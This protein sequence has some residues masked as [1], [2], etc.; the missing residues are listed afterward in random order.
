MSSGTGSSS[1]PPEA[2]VLCIDLGTT[3]CKIAVVQV[4]GDSV[5]SV[6]PTTVMES[7]AFLRGVGAYEEFG[8]ELARRGANIEQPS[9]G[10]AVAFPVPISHLAGGTEP[11][12]MSWPRGVHTIEEQLGRRFGS[13]R[14]TML[15]DAVAFALGSIQ[16]EP[17]GEASGRTLYLTLGMDFGGAIAEPS[18][19]YVTPAELNVLL[20]GTVWPNGH[21]G[22]PAQILMEQ[23]YVR[24]D[25]REW[26]AEARRGFGELTGWVAGE[27]SKRRAV[28][29]VVL[30]GGRAN[31]VDVD[32]VGRGMR[33]V[34][35]TPPPIRIDG[36]DESAL[37]GA[38]FAWVTRY[39][40]RRP[41]AE[42]IAEP[43]AQSNSR[44]R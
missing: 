41:L 20:R 30:G 17:S 14:V 27:V 31:I 21:R 16:R 10:L 2:A 32:D 29:A 8:D 12:G 23:P 44:G 22:S 13:P 38:A 19:G 4:V 5:G 34:G 24:T 15:N 11:P 39:V 42:I 9:A 35:A 28:E 36:R 6:A 7:A 1:Q 25:G 37:A 26:D 18:I 33:A 3:R 40:Q 43:W